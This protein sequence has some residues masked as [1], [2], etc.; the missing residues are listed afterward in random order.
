MSSFISKLD[1]P[2]LELAIVDDFRTADWAEIIKFPKL[3][4]QKSMQFL[5]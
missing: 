2:K 1:E 3:V 5:Q 4:Y